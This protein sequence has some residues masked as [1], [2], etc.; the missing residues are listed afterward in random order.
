MT[1]PRVALLPYAEILIF[2]TLFHLLYE[3]L[4]TKK[5]FFLIIALICS[6]SLQV[7]LPN[8]LHSRVFHCARTKRNG[9]PNRSEFKA[10]GSIT[11]G[12]VLD[13]SLH[14]LLYNNLQKSRVGESPAISQT[15]NLLGLHGIYE[16]K[17]LTDQW[18]DGSLF[19]LKIYNL[20]HLIRLKIF[21]FFFKKS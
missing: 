7:T 18:Q 3:K 10:L 4:H 12:W 16:K 2:H 21:I 14:A 13:Y 8:S 20:S 6:Y 19:L 11:M 15:W 1:S 5:H 9:L 17:L